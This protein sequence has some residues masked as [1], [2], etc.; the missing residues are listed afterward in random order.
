MGSPKKSL[1]GRLAGRAARPVAVSVC[2]LL[3]L[4]AVGI[5]FFTRDSRTRHASAIPDATATSSAVPYA[6]PSKEYIY[7]GGRLV[8]IEAP[9]SP[10]DEPPSSFDLS[11]TAA[12]N[13]TR[14]TLAWAAPAEAVDH[15]RVQR[16]GV[17]SG[18]VDIGP[19][20]GAGET[21]YSDLTVEVG[22]A[23]V[24]R[25]L[26][27]RPGATTPSSHSDLDIATLAFFVD[28]PLLPTQTVIKSV[29]ITE[30]RQAVDAVRATAGLTA[31]VWPGPAPEP[32]GQIYA[33]HV[34]SLRDSL[35][36]ALAALQLPPLPNDSAAA[37]ISRG[38]RVMASHVQ[39]IRDA[40]K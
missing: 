39:Q 13:P 9:E 20:I 11:A 3:S 14:V 36:Q 5:S 34:Q 24:Y 4:T 37:G 40:L 15:Y 33:A 38:Q 31:T 2:A 16:R 26:A 19:V 8:A 32:Q 1:A 10:A 7:I 28:D 21:S 23:Y 6:T 22:K 35:G 29:H 18:F 17:G 12:R 25:V 27:Y 30:L